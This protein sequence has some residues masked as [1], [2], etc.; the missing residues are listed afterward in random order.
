MLLDVVDDVIVSDSYRVGFF[1]HLVFLL[2]NN[3]VAGYFQRAG[4]SFIVSTAEADEDT[5]L[6]WAM[7]LSHYARFLMERGHFQKAYDQF[8]SA[9]TTN[10]KIQGNTH[11]QS[12][13][14]LNSMG[15]V[16]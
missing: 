9:Y 7:S 8:Q 2:K 10:C 12:I 4:F 16:V 1:K 11:P 15:K 5:F 3:V 13:V 6:L 14:L